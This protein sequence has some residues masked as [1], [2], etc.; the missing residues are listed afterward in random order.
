MWEDFSA[1]DTIPLSLL[2]SENSLKWNKRFPS[3]FPIDFA[4]RDRAKSEEKTHSKKSIIYN[5]RPNHHS[6]AIF[7][8]F[9]FIFILD[10]EKH[11]IRY[12]I[13]FY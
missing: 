13:Q 5:A 1:W 8:R 6:F 11:N 9:R 4:I 7:V 2:N 3:N 10:M 12:A